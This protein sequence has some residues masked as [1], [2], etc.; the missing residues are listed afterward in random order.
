MAGVFPVRSR[1]ILTFEQIDDP[2]EIVMVGSSCFT[3]VYSLGR[4]RH[5]GV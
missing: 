2:A 1:P 3:E 4:A 5:I